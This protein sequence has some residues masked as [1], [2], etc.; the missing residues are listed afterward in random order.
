MKIL[1][2]EE[3]PKKGAHLAHLS[4]QILQFTQKY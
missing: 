2:R 4:G 1:P 3:P